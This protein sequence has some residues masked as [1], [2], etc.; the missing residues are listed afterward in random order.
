[1]G[2]DTDLREVL[3]RNP[4]IIDVRIPE[5]FSAEHIDGAENLPLATLDKHLPNWKDDRPVV[6]YC[7]RGVQSGMAMRKMK[8]FGIEV[9]NGGAIGSLRNQLSRRAGNA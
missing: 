6:V 5:Q 2:L 9:Y 4:R 1:M 7:N 3:A 8:K